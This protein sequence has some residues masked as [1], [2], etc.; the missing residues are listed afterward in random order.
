MPVCEDCRDRV[1]EC[2]QKNNSKPLLCSSVV[3]EYVECVEK[4]R[5]VR[6]SLLN[7][8]LKHTFEHVRSKYSACSLAEALVSNRQSYI[9]NVNSTLCLQ[10]LIQAPNQQV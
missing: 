9:Y 3:R 2:Y 6:W 5:R 4:Y 1:D 7:H 8:Q 10:G